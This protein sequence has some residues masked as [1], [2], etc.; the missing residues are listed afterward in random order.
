M[1]GTRWVTPSTVDSL[2]LDVSMSNVQL[3]ATAAGIVSLMN[4][5]ENYFGAY[6]LPVTTAEFVEAATRFEQH[7]QN[8]RS[9]VASRVA[10]DFDGQPTTNTVDVMVGVSVRD[11]QV[12]LPLILHPTDAPSSSGAVH[13][14]S[15]FTL[16]DAPFHIGCA[17]GAV[18]ER[19]CAVVSPCTGRCLGL[20]FDAPCAGAAA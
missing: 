16:H 14:D 12:L 4:V 15:Q 17:V 6:P 19:W 11:L 10:R 1:G 2:T 13:E 5:Q 8:M 20:P 9:R 7:G 18:R 3:V